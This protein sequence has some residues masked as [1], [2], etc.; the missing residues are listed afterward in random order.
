MTRLRW[1]ALLFAGLLAAASVSFNRP[2]TFTLLDPQGGPVDEVYVAYS[3]VGRRL[4]FVHPVTYQAK[5]L[6]LVRESG[7]GLVTLPAAFHI[8]LPFPAQ[9]YPSLSVEMV[10]VPSL[11][12]AWGRFGDGSPSRPALFELDEDGMRAIVFD[13]RDRP[14]PWEGTLR[15]L[16]SLIGRLV[17]RPDRE[18]PLRETDPDTAARTRELIVHFRG[19][20]EAFLARYAGDERPRP[21]MP[22][23]VRWSSAEDQR[24]WID[25]IDANLAREPRW[26]MFIERLFARELEALEKLDGTLAPQ[27]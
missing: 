18:G 26:G 22:D 21:E 13:L 8:H 15:T 1:V 9:T 4:N 25:A 7:A 2:R 24:R 11:H 16:S 17:H 20:Y 6:A 19:E 5:S 12:N 3:Y 10:Y 14:E 23:H 27:R